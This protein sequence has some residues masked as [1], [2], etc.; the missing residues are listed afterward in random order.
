[1][2]EPASVATDA[3]AVGTVG[4]QPTVFYDGSCPMCRREI[5]FYKGQV[6]ASEVAWVDISACSNGGVAP[7]LVAPD[8]TRD[9]AMRRFHVRRADGELVSGA[10]AFAVLWSHLPRW[11]WLGRAAQLPLVSTLLEASYRLFL[12]VRPYLQRL[13]RRNER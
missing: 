10:A 3:K 2:V 12:P 9:A 4:A 11:R 5:G 1:M 8:L 6:G 7:D 13:F